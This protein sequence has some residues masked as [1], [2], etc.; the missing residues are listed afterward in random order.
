MK[1]Y[2]F[3]MFAV[4]AAPNEMSPTSLVEV[5]RALKEEYCR[6]FMQGVLMTDVTVNV[7]PVYETTIS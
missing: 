6:Q 5:T 4:V 3:S 1:L 2:K 7:E